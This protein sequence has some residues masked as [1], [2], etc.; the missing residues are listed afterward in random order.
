MT[1]AGKGT[2]E[3]A[4]LDPH[5]HRDKVRPAISPVPDKEGTY[6][7]EYVAMETGLHSINVFFTGRQIP[8]SP[9]GVNVA[10]GRLYE[11]TL[12]FY[13]SFFSSSFLRKKLFFC[14]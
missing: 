5:G 4:I 9:F 10:P 3:V 1:E 13:V 12:F 7:V 2:I 11:C 14:F 8:G 6:L